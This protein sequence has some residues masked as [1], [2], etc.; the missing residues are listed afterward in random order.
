MTGAPSQELVL[1]QCIVE[2]DSNGSA[3]KIKIRV[4]AVGETADAAGREARL[5]F[6]RQMAMLEADLERG[7][8]ATLELIGAV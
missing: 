3:G 5:E 2:I 7:W 1:P 8:G 4:R 6:V